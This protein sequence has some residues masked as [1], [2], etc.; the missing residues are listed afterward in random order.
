MEKYFDSDVLCHILSYLNKTCSMNLLGI[1]KKL[2]K[3]K[4]LIYGKYVFDLNKIKHLPDDIL[5]LI[6]HIKIPTYC[7]NLNLIPFIN[8]RSLESQNKFFNI[9]F[10]FC[11]LSNISN[12]ITELYF[13]QEYITINCLPKNLITLDIKTTNLSCLLNYLPKTIKHLTLRC[14]LFDVGLDKLNNLELLESLR[15]KSNK[16]NDDLYDLQE[17]L[18]LLEIT[19]SIFNKPVGLLPKKLITLIIKSNAFNNSLKYLPKTL[20]KIMIHSNMFNKKINKLPK[21]LILLDIKCHLFNQPL[22]NLPLALKKLII[23][24]FIMSFSLNNLPKTLIE[25]TINC[26]LFNDH[27]NELP[28]DL[29]ILNLISEQFNQELTNLPSNLKKLN[30]ICKSFNRSLDNLPNNLEELIV[31]SDTIFTKIINK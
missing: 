1:T 11:N 8:L 23:N 19:S 2:Q 14:K 17:T 28:S 10:N 26:T 30:V 12:T 18:K 15:I 20:K 22:N 31:I 24:A 3:H 4:K 9:H 7:D 13:T 25:L 5:K 27:I 16:F 29:H 21:N 6:N